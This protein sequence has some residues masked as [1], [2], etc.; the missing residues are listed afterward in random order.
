MII[1]I[2]GLLSTILF[3]FYKPYFLQSISG[4]AGNQGTISLFVEGVDGEAPSVNITYP[5]DG[6]TYTS[7]RTE[8]N[9]T[10]SDN[11][12]LSACWYSLNS[13]ATNVSITCGNN[14]S[15]ITSSEGSNTWIVYANDTSGNENSSSV[16]FSVSS[17]VSP[18]A[19]TGSGGGGGGG[20][21]LPTLASPRFEVSPEE[22]NIF[23]VSG[24]TGEGEI[25]VKNLHNSDISVDIEL[26]GI[27]EFTSLNTNRIYLEKGVSKSVLVFVSPDEQ[28]VY[29]GKIIF[30]SANTL[31][32]VLVLVNVRSGQALFDVSLTIPERYKKIF[33]GEG[34]K[35]FV[36]LLQVGPAAEVDVIANYIIKDFFGNTLLEEKETFRVYE[37]KDLGKEFSRLD[38]PSG[39]YVMAVEV[40]YPGGFAVSSA[41]FEVGSRIN[42]TLVFAGVIVLISAI[43]IGWSILRYKKSK[44]YYIR[45]KR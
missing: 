26:T 8:L 29:A 24:E 17:S 20:G 44:K 42:R 31:K 19:G 30:K 37:K 18:P 1:V 23:V 40:T 12:G 43:V 7:H 34:L 33:S 36:S 11:F 38:L 21:G 27:G 28:G 6:E 22:L 39:D 25:F 45:R 41:H 14:A 10:V 16:T 2:L 9:Y 5:L 35:A 13:G 3:I 4:R 15:G 32:E